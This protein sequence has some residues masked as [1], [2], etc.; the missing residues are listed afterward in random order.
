[1]SDERMMTLEEQG[2]VK[3]AAAARY[4][5]LNV[6]PETAEY[7]FERFTAKQARAALIQD[8]DSDPKIAKLAKCIKAKVEESKKDKDEDAQDA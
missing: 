6:R 2:V 5:E 1:M 8:P 3:A 4:R 7:L